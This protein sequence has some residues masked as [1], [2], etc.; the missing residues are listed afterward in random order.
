MNIELGNWGIVYAFVALL[1]PPTAVLAGAAVTARLNRKNAQLAMDAQQ[2]ES[3]RTRI[4]D[5]TV[6]FMSAARRRRQL[7]VDL[8]G[9]E[10]QREQ[11]APKLTAGGASDELG[12][13]AITM[14]EEQRRDLER[15]REA[16]DQEMSS[17]AAR[18]QLYSPALY[19]TAHTI[20]AGI[21]S[22]KIDSPGV[23]EAGLQEMVAEATKII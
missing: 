6:S 21:E 7:E 5:A 11:V 13:A 16:L 12:M 19:R 2:D 4:A 1:A 18:L 17:E 23:L 14:V 20:A 22:G 10:L 9:H 15:R 3:K 8:K